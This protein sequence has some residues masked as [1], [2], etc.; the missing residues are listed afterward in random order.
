MIR[1]VAIDDEPLALRQ[2]VKYIEKIP[3]LELITT[4]RNA[5]EAQQVLAE[6]DVELIFVDII[7]KNVYK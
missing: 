3:D 1:C 6:N 5:A 4:C 7:K 2:I